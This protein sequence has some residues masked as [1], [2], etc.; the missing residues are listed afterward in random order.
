MG[1]VGVKII[2]CTKGWTS[3]EGQNRK[4][5]RLLS[6]FG[7]TEWKQPPSF[8]K[9]A[10]LAIRRQREQKSGRAY[11]RNRR[12]KTIMLIFK[13]PFSCLIKKPIV[14]SMPK[15]LW[16][17]ILAV[18]NSLRTLSPLL[19]SPHPGFG[20]KNGWWKQGCRI[21]KVKKANAF[22]KKPDSK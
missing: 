2:F 1:K 11:S 14:F 8:R 3:S 9:G 22:P 15:I 4:D 18:D 13:K 12:K 16:V 6:Q 19:S 17:W 21:G 7:H 10:T 20:K 5:L